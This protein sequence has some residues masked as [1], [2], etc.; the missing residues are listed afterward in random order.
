MLWGKTRRVEVPWLQAQG[1]IELRG[2]PC[3]VVKEKDVTGY[4]GCRK[5]KQH[6]GRSFLCAGYLMSQT[7]GKPAW[8][9]KD[10][11]NDQPLLLE[12]LMLCVQTAFVAA[13]R[14]RRAATKEKKTI[15]GHERPR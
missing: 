1:D 11:R 7:G 5:L 9:R 4:G 6:K 10:K 15:F 12:Q 3:A 13:R 8:F 2:V 14:E